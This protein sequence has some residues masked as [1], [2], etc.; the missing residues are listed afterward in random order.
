M[1][2]LTGYAHRKSITIDGSTAGA[3]TNYQMLLKVH[4]DLDNFY[5]LSAES[6]AI[7]G[8][9][10]ERHALMPAHKTDIY[11][12]NKT[13][14]GSSRKYLAYD[15]DPN[16]TQIRLY[17]SDDLDGAWTGYSGNPILTSASQ[18]YRCPSV[19]FDGTTFHMF[20]WDRLHDTFERWTST[21]GISFT[22]QETILTETGGDINFCIWF[23]P[24]DNLWY[25]YHTKWVTG[26]KWAYVRKAADIT[27]LAGAS[28]SSTGL[29]GMTIWST[30]FR[31]GEY[32]FAGELYDD[33]YWTVKIYHSAT[34]DSDL[35]ECDNSPVLTNDD[36]CPRL[37]SIGASAY[38]YTAHRDS[39][40]WYEE[41]R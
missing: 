3:Q 24:N 26:T 12:V 18:E 23:N 13:V 6:V 15:S 34:P 30:I 17:Y 25:L 36:A 11:E 28:E 22:Y 21:D 40:E 9:P 41:T 29:S 7:T 31:D 14:D 8:D 5:G 20:L 38:L 1:A 27:A 33:P 39:G 19:A 2:W 4:Y 16:G 32:W 10:T 37:C 35:V